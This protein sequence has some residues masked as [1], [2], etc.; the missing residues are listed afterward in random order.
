MTYQQTIEGLLHTGLIFKQAYEKSSSKIVDAYLYN[1][2]FTEESQRKIFEAWSILLTKEKLDEWLI[3]YGIPNQSKPKT[4]AIIMAGNIPLVGMHDLFCVLISGHNALVKLSSDDKVLPMWIIQELIKFN[5]EFE[6]R[7]KVAD[8]QINK[9]HFDAV[10]ATGSNNSNRYFEYYFRNYPQI[11]RQN[12]TSVAVLT[13]DEKPDDIKL[14]ADDIFMHFGLGC[15][16]VS[17][18]YLPDGMALD[19][20]FENFMGY[21]DFINHNKYVNN[22]NYHKAIWLMNQDKFYDNNFILL[23]K[24]EGL[25]SPLASLYFEYYDE[26]DVLKSRLDEQEKEIQC[27]VSKLNFNHSVPFGKA[28]RPE[29]NDYADRIDT[30]A[31]LLAL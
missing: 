14:L 20:L 23:K 3:P 21:A 27:V 18:L 30:I 13:G 24:D 11:L 22:Y 4:I 10:I 16:N 5:P 28:Q 9:M 26:I 17:K 29:W 25:H 8:D 1:N 6:E 19:I 7:I 12:R 15:R 2:W 31:F